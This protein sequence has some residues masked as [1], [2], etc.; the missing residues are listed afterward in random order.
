[1]IDPHASPNELSHEYKL[2]LV[3]EVSNNYDAVIIAVAHQ[4]YKDLSL[5]YYKSIM[6]GSPILIDLKGVFEPSEVDIP[7]WRL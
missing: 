6:N 5:D 1:L 4:E 7:Y 2:A 3:D